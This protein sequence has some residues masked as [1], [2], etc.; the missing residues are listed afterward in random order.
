M[1]VILLELVY[2]TY[3]LFPHPIIINIFI[4]YI[5]NN[6]LWNNNFFIAISI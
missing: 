3:L 2:Y 6:S 1:L 5:Y 4:Y